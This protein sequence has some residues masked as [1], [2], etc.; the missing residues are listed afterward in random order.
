MI[1]YDNLVGATVP[2]AAAFI[3]WTLRQFIIS[4]V[5]PKGPKGDK[6][7][8]GPE[9]SIKNFRVIV[10]LLCSEL[11]GRYMFA[12]EARQRFDKIESRLDALIE[13]LER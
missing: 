9:M 7:D 10:D 5:G 2:A 11:N 1:N 4:T 13:R 8:M 12:I 3:V 6:G